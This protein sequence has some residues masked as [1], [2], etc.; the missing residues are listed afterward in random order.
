MLLLL[1]HLADRSGRVT[2]DGIHL[3]LRL[4]HDLL[5]DLVASRRPSVTTGL[6]RLK[7]EGHEPP[8]ELD[9]YL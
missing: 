8:T 9:P 6:A 1:W 3:P 4:S 2:P 5:S 7:R